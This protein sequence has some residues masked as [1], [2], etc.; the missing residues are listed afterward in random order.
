MAKLVATLPQEPFQN[1]DW[2]FSKLVK[3]TSRMLRNQ[4]IL[5]ATDYATKRVEAWTLGTNITIIIAKFL[6][7]H[8]LMKFGCPL[9]IVTNQ[10]KYPFH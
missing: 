9:T 4:Y 8:I 2:I 5:M 1:G 10:L 3:P 7:E 6:Y